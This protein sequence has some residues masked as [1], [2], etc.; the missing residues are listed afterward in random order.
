[1]PHTGRAR[2]E[3]RPGIRT[4]PFKSVIVAFEIVG[5]YVLILRV[6]H[7][8]CDLKHVFKPEP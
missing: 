8:A 3:L 2:D 5:N 1:M 4:R 7:G 6:L